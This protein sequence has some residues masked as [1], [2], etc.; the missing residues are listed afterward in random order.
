MKGKSLIHKNWEEAFHWE[1]CPLCYLVQKAL[2]SYME[3]FL[4][5]NVNDVLLRKSIREKGGFCENHHLQLLTFRDFL[6]ISIIY[7]DIIKNFIIPSLKNKEIPETK[8]CI[9]CEKEEEYEKLYIQSLSEVLKNQETFNLWKEIAYDF[10]Q[11]HKEKIKTISPDTYKRIEPYLS[12]KKRKYPEY[13]YESF[14][15]DKDYSELF[16]KKLRILELKKPK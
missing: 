4:Y 2:R 11:P 1:G 12:H 5:E 16:L 9:F 10:C 6:G 7:E 15:W 3:N 13:F 14:S 8:S